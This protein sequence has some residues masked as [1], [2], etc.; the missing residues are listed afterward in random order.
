[1][2]EPTK[3]IP[4]SDADYLRIMT[5]AIFQAGFNWDVIEKKWP[6]FEA[7]FD[8][9][10]VQAVASFDDNKID[11]LCQD[12]RIVRNRSKITATVHNARTI[13]TKEA[14]HGSFKKYLA[15]LSSFETCVQDLR[16]A[17]K[18]LGDFGAF[19]F[20]WVVGEPTPT[21]HE[22]CASRGITPLDD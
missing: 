8:Q 22:W 18:W 10:D 3:I 12:T 20:L 6:G 17:F 2:K 14:E 9:F 19:Y 5:K 16:K 21:Y 1:M 4:K 15:S 13:I 7:A 11:E